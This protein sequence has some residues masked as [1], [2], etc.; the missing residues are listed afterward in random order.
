MPV[1]VSVRPRRPSVKAARVRAA[2]Q[3]TLDA[4]GAGDLAVSVV[5]VSDGALHALNRDWLGHDHPT[6]VISFKLREDGDPDPLLG[7]VVVSA[8]R[9]AAEAAA[10]GIDFE[11][12][13]LRY[14]VHGCLHLLGYDDARPRARARMRGRQEEILR[15]VRGRVRGRGGGRRR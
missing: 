6:D 7:E 11:E 8:D 3:A 1:E 5:V 14:V 4:E 10:R 2:A 15:G 13:L 12:E 9:A